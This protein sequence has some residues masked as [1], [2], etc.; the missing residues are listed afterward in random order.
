[1]KRCIILFQFLWFVGQFTYAQLNCK[2]LQR[3]DSSFTSCFHKN[4]TLSTHLAWE[5]DKRS[6]RATAYNNQGKILYEFYVRKFA[7]H[8]SVYADYYP[9]GQVSK[10]EYSSAPDGG[11]QW[12][13]KFMQFDLNGNLTSSHED[14]TDNF[15]N[16]I[17]SPARMF[18]EEKDQPFKKQEPIKD[19]IACAELYFSVLELKNSTKSSLK[20]SLKP[21]HRSGELKSFIIKEGGSLRVDS[22]MQAEFFEEPDKSLDIKIEWAKVRKRANFLVQKELPVKTGKTKTVYQWLIKGMK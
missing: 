22:V 9:N 11:I 5:K 21:K 17:N 18:R 10:V 19:V 15:G 4:K 3:R 1:M 20:V 13:R 16:P 12:Y 6:G 14:G 2:T 7:G 8:A